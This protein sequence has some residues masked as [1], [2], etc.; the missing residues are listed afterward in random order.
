MVRTVIRDRF[1]PAIA[2]V[3]RAEGPRVADRYRNMW[4]VMQG[5]CQRVGHGEPSRW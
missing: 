1:L 3:T 4:Y 5:P 2:F